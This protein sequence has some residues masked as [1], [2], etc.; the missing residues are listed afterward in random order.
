MPGRGGGILISASL[1][2]GEV[3]PG[4]FNFG[5]ILHKELLLLLPSG[6]HT[7]RIHFCRLRDDCSHGSDDDGG[8]G[9][10]DDCC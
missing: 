6:M 5:N 2:C 8:H 4:K 10:G 3:V 1:Y 7:Q 9:H